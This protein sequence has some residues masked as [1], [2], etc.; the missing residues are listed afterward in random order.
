M[1]I[2]VL[3]ALLAL[4]LPCAV[5]A[6]R[7]QSSATLTAALQR[8]VTGVA[9]LAE[10][11]YVFPDTG[12]M[13]A[14][15]LR[16]RLAEGAYSGITEPAQLADRL[17]RDMQAINGDRHLYVNYAGAPGS[18]NAGGETAGPRLEMRRPGDPVAPDRLAAVRRATT[19]SKRC[20]DWT[21]TWAIWRSRRCAHRGAPR[22]MR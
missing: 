12:R 5:G 20:N 16:K 1:T 17:T 21:A 13:V 22:S 19:T 14:D 18:P 10:Q 11:N 6:Q 8:V 15:H 2:R 4:A 3:A 7:Q 9:G